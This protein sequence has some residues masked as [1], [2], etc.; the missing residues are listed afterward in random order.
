MKHRQTGI[1]VVVAG[2]LGTAGWLHYH[3]QAN[4]PTASPQAADETSALVHTQAVNMQSLPEILTVFGDVAAGKIVTVSFPRAGLVSQLQVV[5]GQ[6]VQRGAALATLVSDPS[7]QTAYAQAVNAEQFA[8]GELKRNQDLFALQLATQSQVDAARKSQ[9]DAASALEAQRKLG[10][11]LG[12]ATVYAPSDG[13]VNALA[14][15]QGDRIQPGAPILQLGRL[16]TLR[17]QLGIEP[18]ESR[19]VRTGMPVTLTTV[20]NREQ[21]V[22]AVIDAIQNVVDSKTQLVNATVVLPAGSARFLIPGMHVQGA[23]QVAQHQAWAVPREALLSD[24]DG[25]YLFQVAQGKARRVSVRKI[26][27]S[28]NL[29]GVDG[30]LDSTLP[31]VVLGNY[32]L[33]NGMK[34]REAKR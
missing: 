27:E 12:S 10:G 6:R 11:N 17:I 34:V 2:V 30:A 28:G 13:V 8:R 15:A 20:Q 19:L 32:E 23:I 25:G 7:A 24:N 3:G 31:V 33:Q 9:R 21:R 26:A 5:A 22:D 1:A 29:V 14:V 16:D 4:G 18:E